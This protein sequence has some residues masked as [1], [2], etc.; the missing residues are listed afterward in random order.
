MCI[1]MPS[2]GTGV[3]LDL[4]DVNARLADEEFVVL[5]LGADLHRD[6]AQLLL[7]SHLLQ[8]LGRLLHVLLGPAQLHDVAVHPEVGEADLHVGQ[9]F[10]NLLDVLPLGPDQLSDH[11]PL[12][13]QS[14][15][16]QR[17]QRLTHDG[18]LVDID[19]AGEDGPA[20]QFTIIRRYRKLN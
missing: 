5:Q 4:L 13:H 12:L 2:P 10:E 15:G 17:Q 3:V 19:G 16:L 7:L 6:A 14:H 20:F 9:V 18:L 8:Q 11:V 1:N